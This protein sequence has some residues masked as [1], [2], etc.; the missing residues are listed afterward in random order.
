MLSY[1]LKC[2]KNTESKN[3]KVIRRRN[4]RIMFLSKCEVYDSKISKF[5]KEQEASG[6]L[7]GLGIKTSLSK[8]PLFGPLLF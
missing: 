4:G 3:P 2:R 1:C 5:I 6:L 7:S 8:I